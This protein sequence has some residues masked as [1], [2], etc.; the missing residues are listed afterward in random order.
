MHFPFSKNKKKGHTNDKATAPKPPK[1][2][3]LTPETSQALSIFQASPPVADHL[4]D[5]PR[6]GIDREETS[7]TLSAGVSAVQNGPSLFRGGS[8][9]SLLS[10]ERSPS[11]AS[12]LDRTKDPRGLTVLHEPK[13]PPSLDIVFVHGLGGSSRATWCHNHD[14]EYFWPFKWLPQEPGIQGARISSFG[15][16][17]NFSATGPSPASSVNEFAKSLLLSLKFA[18]DENLE[19]VNIGEKPIIFIVHSMG[20]LV[21]K[22]A[23]LLGQNDPEY[24]EIV[25]K[26]S[27]ILFLATPHRGSNLAELLNK[28]LQISFMHTPKQYITD[29]NRNSAALES[30]NDEFRHVSHTLKIVSFYETLETKVRATKMMI[31]EKDSAVLG[32]PNEI[33]IAV[34]AD[35]NTICKFPSREDVNYVTFRNL[36]KSTVD[37]FR[38]KVKKLLETFEDTQDLATML[39]TS[40]D[41]GDDLEFFRSRWADGTCAWIESD[42]IFSNWQDGETETNILWLFARPASGKSVLLS[43]IV[44]ELL[45]TQDRVCAFYFFRFDNQAKRSLGNCLRSLAYQI[46]IQLP[47]YRQ[48]LLDMNIRTAGLSKL[49][50]RAVWQKIFVGALFKEQDLPPIYIAIDALDEADDREFLLELF[51]TIP[52][53]SIPIKL[54]I[55]SRPS[56]EIGLQF[57]RLK[58]KTTVDVLPLN[59]TDRDIRAFV[60]K[61]TQIW[62]VSKDYKQQ[63]IDRLLQTGQNNFLWVTIVTKRVLKCVSIAEMETILNDL[64]PDM[65]NLYQRMEARIEPR[66]VDLAKTILIWAACSRRPLTMVE[67]AE[68]LQPESPELLQTLDDTINHVCE[69]FV[70]VG[71][72]KHLLMVHKTAK[73]YLT[74]ITKG[75]LAINPIETHKFMFA[76]CMSIMGRIT[77]QRAERRGPADSNVASEKYKPFEYAMTSWAYHLNLCNP[78]DQELKVLFEFLKSKT[79]LIWISALASLGKLKQLVYASKGLSSLVRKI[80]K[81]DSGQDPAFRWLEGLESVEMWAVDLLK[82]VGKFS[83]DLTTKNISI[84]DHVA[85]FC[86]RGSMI[87]QNFAKGARSPPGLSIRGISA[88]KWDDSLAKLTMQKGIMPA[89]IRNSGSC[90]AIA[91]AGIKGKIIIYDAVTFEVT[92]V[93]EHKEIIKATSFSNKGDRLV[94]SGF[95]TT[96]IWDIKSGVVVWQKPNLLGCRAMTI[97]FSPDDSKLFLGAED[98]Q[99]WKINLYKPTPGM[100]ETLAEWSLVDRELLRDDDAIDRTVA[101]VPWR[102]AFDAELKHIA[103]SYRGSPMAV[104]SIDPPELISHCFRQQSDLEMGNGWT[105]VDQVLW[106]PHTD[107]VLG[108]YQGGHVFKWHPYNDT[109]QEL[110]VE[111][112]VIACN[113]EG[114]LF[115]TGDYV[116]T[117]KLFNYEDFCMIYRL[118]FDG[119]IRDLAFSPDSKLLFD[120]RGQS[121]NVWEP[122]A[123]IRLDDIDG[124]TSEVGS[125]VDSNPISEVIAEVRDPITA[126]AVHS[127]GHYHAIGNDCGVIS[128]ISTRVK[129]SNGSVGLLTSP[130]MMTVTNLDWSQD[131]SHLACGSLTG[132]IDILA[133]IPPS[134]ENH[135][136]AHKPIAQIKVEID[137]GAWKFF[138]NREGT[139][140]FVEKGSV[141]DVWSVKSKTAIASRA[142]T[143]IGPSQQWM[144]H[145]TDP[146]ILLAFELDVIKAYSWTG[147]DEVFSWDIERPLPSIES[148]APTRTNSDSPHGEQKDDTSLIIKYPTSRY[149]LMHSDHKS[150]QAPRTK[151]TQI[152]D[153]S[154]MSTHSPSASAT[155]VATPIPASVQMEVDIPLGVLPRKGLALHA[156]G[157][158]ASNDAKEWGDGGVD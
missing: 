48:A 69:Q 4:Q 21:A 95:K 60:E 142:K 39:A 116:G 68:F 115:V 130:S 79:V 125:E 10:R 49:D 46:A 152:I 103:V 117:I 148:P 3:K 12:K 91:T 30:I 32:Y 66:N 84:R 113:P 54:I 76:K 50:A 9:G 135:Q 55:S 47:S 118:S 122:N 151:I 65:K 83:T 28:I 133:I 96:K 29:L 94:S 141:V 138:L 108:L 72:T 7:N 2:S 67:L 137:G 110:D 27:S 132:I 155:I 23:F 156:A 34:N 119:S 74:K 153:T 53:A 59:N 58:T 85:P 26:V 25:S 19:E 20:G 89:S 24:S 111:A 62:H 139:L 127:G 5:S 52:F 18:K 136:W 158:W 31:V 92:Y 97:S 36:L 143:L 6:R 147:L 98:R 101:L 102:M 44:R 38:K 128:I 145:P 45:A 93:L 87:Y 41:I 73:E 144:K 35:H 43:Y 106:Q 64:P 81:Q 149:I 33:S 11:N 42:P 157:G 37:K 80:R 88:T 57:D 70:V 107:E 154:L 77:S 1:G 109:Q 8:S 56:P 15:Y 150:S 61:E 13:T 105:P 16:D 123:L 40:Q 71:S 99:I 112:S 120:I 114:T 124:P 63:V 131:G 51:Q 129:D 75:R 126:L 82:I 22:K 78:G 100:N 121:C 14:P 17:A 90:I 140:L 86:P 104:W 146:S 134:K